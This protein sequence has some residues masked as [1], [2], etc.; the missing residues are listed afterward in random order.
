MAPLLEMTA[1]ESAGSVTAAPPLRRATRLNVAAVAGSVGVSAM[2]LAANLATGVI[3][4]RTL[5]TA[6]KG[7]L[8]ALFV[9]VTT[10]GNLSL[11]GLPEAL[12]YRIG[13]ATRHRGVLATTGIV[14]SLALAV[15]ASWHRPGRHRLGF[16]GAAP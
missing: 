14:W 12:T 1:R 6:G 2:V 10:L 3:T 5:D 16:R 13:R 4:A 9:L 15:P 8:A 7:E 11:Y